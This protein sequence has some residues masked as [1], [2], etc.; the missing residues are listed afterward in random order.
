MYTDFDIQNVHSVIS[1]NFCI[2]K[3]K[4][5]RD[6]DKIWLRKYR[7]AQLTNQRWKYGLLTCYDKNKKKTAPK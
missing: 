4:K 3:I 7:N 5:K 6:D 2:H 1:N